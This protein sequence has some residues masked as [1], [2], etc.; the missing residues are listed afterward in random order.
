LII[1]ILKI[2]LKIFF[3]EEIEAEENDMD[4]IPDDD[5]MDSDYEY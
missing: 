1:N 2:N 4:N 5:N 3:D